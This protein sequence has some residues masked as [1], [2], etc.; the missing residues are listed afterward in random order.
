MNRKPLVGVAIGILGVIIIAVAVL[1][2]SDFLKSVVPKD[3]E[4]P[5]SLKTISSDIKPLDVQ[6]NDISVL[7]VSEKEAILELKFD[8]SNPN[9]KPILLEMISFDIF[10]NDIKVGYGE[11][12]ERLSGQ[13]TSSN[14][15]TVLSDSSLTVHDKMTIKNTGNNPEFWLTLQQGTPEWRIKGEAFYSTTSAFSGLADS[16]VFDFTK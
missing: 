9:N 8:V 13:Y 11:I 7:S 10:E 5:G 15:Y 1:P 14:Y 4:L 12:G 16:T 2:G 6:L 3:V